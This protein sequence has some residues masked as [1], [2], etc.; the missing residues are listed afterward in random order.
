VSLLDERRSSA[1]TLAPELAAALAADLDAL[2]GT[3]LQQDPAPVDG[4]A[5][6]DAASLPVA[7]VQPMVPTMAWDWRP[8]VTG[9]TD[10]AQYDLL[11]TMPASA[12]RTSVYLP[13]T[14]SMSG[15]YADVVGLLDRFPLPQRLEQVRAGLRPPCGE[16]AST[17]NPPGWTKV[18]DGAGLLRWR[19]DWTVSQTPSGWLADIADSPEEPATLRFRLRDIYGASSPALPR[20]VAVAGSGTDEIDLDPL[21]LQAGE[22]HTLEITA[23]AWGRIHAQPGSWYDPAI[24]ALSAHST[25]RD[26]IPAAQVV[27]PHGILRAQVTG[28]LVAAHPQVTLCVDGDFA[29]RYAG[30]LRTADTVEVAGWTFRAPSRNSTTGL[31]TLAP[32]P[33]DATLTRLTARS[34]ASTP[35]I[36]GIYVQAPGA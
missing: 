32:D 35:Q 3:H 28:I 30:R 33:T 13:S 23:R 5:T 14:S 25:F 18:V 20:L 22:L 24:V 17:P 31:V 19:P 11:D 9:T 7:G 15:V 16:P 26:G 36:A 29:R 2:A 27:G 4:P 10:S 1:T 8:A 34:A 12:D 6:Y 21:P